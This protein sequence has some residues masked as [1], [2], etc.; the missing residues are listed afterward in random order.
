L[1]ALADIGKV[2]DGR[3]KE[4]A[5]EA[6]VDGLRDP[7]PAARHGAVAGLRT[8]GDRAAIGA[9]EAYQAGLSH[10]ESVGVDHAIAAIRRAAKPPAKVGEA[11]LEE[12]RSDLRKLRE[13]VDG[14][15]AKVEPES[16]ARKTRTGKGK[17][18]AR[19]RGA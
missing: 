13:A 6:L 8:L 7:V 15:R 5:R 12:L 1:T 19:D 17:K 4:S 10:Q 2:L 16:D 14:L 18:K 11:E 9:L 3:Y